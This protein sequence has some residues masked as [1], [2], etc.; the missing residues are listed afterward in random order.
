MI[1]T[2]IALGTA[3]A[4]VAAN[5]L[6]RLVAGVQSTEPVALVTMVCVLIV[7]ALVASFIPAR[8]ASRVDPLIA[9]RQE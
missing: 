6:R 5:V 1:M 2:G 9:L 8:K 4:V 7:A 3:G